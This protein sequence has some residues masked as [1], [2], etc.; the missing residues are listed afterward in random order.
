MA[1]VKTLGATVLLLAVVG[2]FAA[3]LGRPEIV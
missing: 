3:G 1:N 2:H